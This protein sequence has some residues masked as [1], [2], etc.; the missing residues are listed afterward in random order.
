MSYY[1]SL[2][3]FRAHHTARGVT[4]SAYADAAVLIQLL[5]ASEWLDAK[6]RSR[7][8]GIKYG[9][10]TQIREWP[11][12]DAYD[13]HGWSIPYDSVP[14]EVEAAT[15]EVTLKVLQTPDVLNKDFAPSK[16]SQVSVTG[17]VSVQYMNSRDIADVQTRFAIVEQAV[18]PV[19][20]RGNGALS[21]VSGDTY[22]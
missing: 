16:Y 8:S 7:Y 2:A 11:R 4:T 10:R 5:V 14:V 12:S 6:Y 22:R 18:S 21:A 17:A 1:G 20:T 15:Y 9:N 13:V 3:G 19:L